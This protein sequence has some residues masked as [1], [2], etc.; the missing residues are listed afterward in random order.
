MKTQTKDSKINI[1]NV[2]FDFDEIKDNQYF[3]KN[4]FATH[5][6]NALHIVF[7]E[8][9][10]LFIRSVRYFAKDIKDP[11]LKKHIRE[12]TAQEGIHN[13]EHERFWEQLEKMNLKPKGFINFYHKSGFD[14]LEKQLFKILP[15]KYAKKLSLSVTAGAEHYTALLGNQILGNW[16]FNKSLLPEEMSHLMRWHAAEELEHKSVAFDVLQEVDDSYSLR[17]TGMAIASFF[18]YFYAV[19]GMTYFIYQDKNKTWDNAA[20]KFV[21]FVNNYSLKPEGSANWKMLLDYLKPGF[22]PDDHDNYHLAEDY[23]KYYDEYYQQKYKN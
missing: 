18:L 5:F 12:F 22:H 7:P 23:F 2:K 15:T 13:R 19:A 14:M 6:L 4:L 8:G 10:R 16:D 11:E 3:N 1:R 9:E 21:D 20:M 17:M